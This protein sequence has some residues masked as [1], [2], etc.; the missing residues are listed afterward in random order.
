MPLSSNVTVSPAV[1]IP[2]KSYCDRGPASS[3]IRAG[4]KPRQPNQPTSATGSLATFASRTDPSRHIGHADACA[5]DD[6]IPLPERA[7]RSAAA[8]ASGS[9]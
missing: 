9:A 2:A 1:R 6:T 7:A 8:W 3:P 5:F 4:A